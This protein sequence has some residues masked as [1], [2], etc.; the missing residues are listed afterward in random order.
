MKRISNDFGLL[1]QRHPVLDFGVFQLNETRVQ[2]EKSVRFPKFAGGSPVS[3]VT[4]GYQGLGKAGPGGRSAVL[5][6]LNKVHL[7]FASRSLPPY[8]AFT[9]S[10]ISRDGMKIN[11]SCCMINLIFDPDLPVEKWSPHACHRSKVKVEP[12]QSTTCP[13]MLSVSIYH[14]FAF[15]FMTQRKAI[16]NCLQENATCLRQ[17]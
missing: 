8:F 15:C 16:V 2:K 5:L 7:S 12:R 1:L 14:L 6:C 3:C 10:T 13:V 4:A 9:M 11:V 17:M